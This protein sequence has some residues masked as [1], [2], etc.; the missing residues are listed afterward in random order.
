MSEDTGGSFPNS[1]LKHPAVPGPFHCARCG[2]HFC[3]QCCFSMP[4][5]T[6]HCR[7]CY[8][9]EAS[10]PVATATAVPASPLR[11]QTY[12]PAARHEEPI[13]P[14]Q[15]CVQHPDVRGVFAC[16]FCGARSCSTCDFFFPPSMHV[17]PQC[18]ASSGGALTP[19]RRKNMMGGLISGAIGTVLIAIAF[20]ATMMEMPAQEI[21]AGILFLVALLAAA[22]GAGLATAAYKKTRSNTIGIWIAVVWNWLLI[23]SVLGLICAGLFMGDE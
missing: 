23:V 21:I 3:V 8:A 9:Q 12:T 4:D 14:G 2:N 16:Q 13:G 1:C 20:G 19:T 5:G 22:I 7:D 10:T 6:V 18:A 17:C 15:G 11:M